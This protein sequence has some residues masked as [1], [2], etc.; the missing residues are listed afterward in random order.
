MSRRILS[1]ILVMFLL[2][3]LAHGERAVCSFE[4]TAQGDSQTARDGQCGAAALTG[5]ERLEAHFLDVTQGDC[6]LLRG[7]TTETGGPAECNIVVDCGTSSGSTK[8]QIRET[9]TGARKSLIK[10]FEGRTKKIDALVIT[11]P[12][13]DHYNL[14]P[15]VLKDF[16][17]DQILIAGEAAEIDRGYGANSVDEAGDLR[18]KKTRY[19]LQAR[20][21][22]IKGLRR[23]AS[24]TAGTYAALDL[25]SA[26]LEIRVLA[27]DVGPAYNKNN[28]SIVLMVTLGEFDLLLTGDATGKTQDAV[29]QANV[30]ER[31][32]CDVLKV[33]HH[34]SFTHGSN[35]GEWTKV[36]RPEVAI[37]SAR[38]GEEHNHPRDAAICCL[39]QHTVGAPRH[40]FRTWGKKVR[41]QR[42]VPVDIPRDAAQS[43][44]HGFNEAIF[45]TATNGNIV[46][47]TDGV[48]YNVEYDVASARALG[49]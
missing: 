2:T 3:F 10:A 24:D 29:I 17:V 34:G 30:D 6:I 20:R 1:V 19:W 22:N 14:I 12:H 23:Y 45:L 18:S 47:T 16:A 21:E 48:K 41:G 39:H 7:Y 46:L 44:T 8:E 49:N 42:S 27:A 26:P 37:I 35:E 36:V 9:A 33:A 31:L 32:D 4:A 25:P 13:T 11:H 38:Y 40:C 5:T 28:R 15:H 43:A